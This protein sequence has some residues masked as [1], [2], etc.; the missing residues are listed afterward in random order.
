MT[1]D[2]LLDGLEPIEKR[3]NQS[4]SDQEVEMLEKRYFWMTGE[5][6]QD[7]CGLVLASAGKFRLPAVDDFTKAQLAEPERFRRTKKVREECETCGGGGVRMFLQ[8][9]WDRRHLA[10]AAR[11]DC[12]NG[13]N[14]PKFPS[15]KEAEALKGFVRWLR[16]NESSTGAV[17]EADRMT[18]ARKAEPE[19]EDDENI[20]F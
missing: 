17:A 12:R 8:R 7:L 11:C 3:Y 13:E 19:V 14:W 16:R 20:P 10:P 9:A 1:K 4:Y 2:Q 18:G 6:W 5:M 15:A